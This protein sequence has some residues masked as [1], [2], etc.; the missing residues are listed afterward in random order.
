[1]PKLAKITAFTV[2]G[3]GNFPLDMLRYDGCW[4]RSSSDSSEIIESMQEI[5]IRG[6]DVREIRLE[7][8]TGNLTAGRWNSFG[9][10]I[11]EV[12]GA[13]PY[14]YIGAQRAWAG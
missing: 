8:A 13:D 14:H 9:W 6:T 7:S 4:P 10:T 5:A 3:Q 11:T 2:K 12:N 1:M